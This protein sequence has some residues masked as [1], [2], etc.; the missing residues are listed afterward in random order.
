MGAQSCKFLLWFV[1]WALVLFS[2]QF[3]RLRMVKNENNSTN[4]H[5]SDTSVAQDIFYS[6]RFRYNHDMIS[7]YL[8]IPKFS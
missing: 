5:G 3:S 7:A 8:G 4:I 2:K 1:L 6:T